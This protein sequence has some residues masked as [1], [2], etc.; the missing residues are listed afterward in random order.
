[1][2]LGEDIEWWFETKLLPKCEELYGKRCVVVIDN[3]STHLRNKRGCNKTDTKKN[4]TTMLEFL[5]SVGVD[6]PR[7]TPNKELKVCRFSFCSTVDIREMCV[8]C[9]IL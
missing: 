9:G 3:A 4:K 8:N 1:V 5:Q 7:T 6:K 2:F